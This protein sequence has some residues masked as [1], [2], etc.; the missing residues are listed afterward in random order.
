MGVFILAL[1]CAVTARTQAIS[2]SIRGT[3][4][5]GTG[6]VVTG[7]KITVTSAETGLQRSVTSNAEGAYVLLE[8]PVG[9]YRLETEAAGFKKY[10]KT[11]YRWT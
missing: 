1:V 2:G 6:A 11:G 8:L 9:H 5:D 4:T 7:A 10:H 3:V